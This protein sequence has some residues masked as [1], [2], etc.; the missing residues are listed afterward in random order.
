MQHSTPVFPSVPVTFTGQSL[1]SHAGVTVLTGFMDALGF[2]RLREDRL[3]QFVPPARGIVPANC[4]DPWPRCS[5]P[6]A[7]MP[8]TWTSCVPQ[9]K[10]DFMTWRPEKIRSRTRSS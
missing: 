5:P 9:L 7:N 4:S 10:W 1:I 8:R 2:G 6:E 3:G